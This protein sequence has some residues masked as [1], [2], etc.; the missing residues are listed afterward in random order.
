MEKEQE[1]EGRRDGKGWLGRDVEEW[2]CGEREREREKHKKKGWAGQLVHL[3]R[4]VLISVRFRINPVISATTS[5]KATFT[6]RAV[7]ATNVKHKMPEP[8]WK[9]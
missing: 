5:H 2:K 1:K 9:V 7:C 6:A 8:V 4:V 3:R